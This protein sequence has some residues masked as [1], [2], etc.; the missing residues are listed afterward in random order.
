MAVATEQKMIAQLRTLLQLTHSEMQLAATRQTQARTDAVRR[1]LAEN[2]RNAESRAER[3]EQALRSLGGTPDI[4]GPIVGRVAAMV[5]AGSEQAQPFEEALLAELS[6]EHQLLD[7]ARYLKALA[8]AADNRGIV[9]LAERLETA[10][11]ATVEWLTT[12]L[13]EEAIGGPAALQRTPVQAV[14]SA[15]FRLSSLPMRTLADR[16]NDVFVQ[17]RNERERLSDAVTQTR[18]TVGELAN[19]AREVF[20]AGRDSGLERAES[21]ARRDGASTTASTVH[22]T[23]AATGS[24]RAS[25]LPVRDYDELNASA[26]IAAIR[27]LSKPEDV[28]TVLAYEEAHKA[29]SGVISATQ[30]HVAD[31]AKQTV[32]I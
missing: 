20:G 1:E 17:A 22:K 15:A 21:V 11:T 31:I 8:E 4:L 30:T 19:G 14:T 28:R 32:G 5:K 2:A 3:I 9:H 26:A 27:K 16:V 18:Q 29:R 12:V 13:A 25:E 10:H 23:R 6:I 7:R 24:L